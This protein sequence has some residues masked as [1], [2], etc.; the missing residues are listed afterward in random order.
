[1]SRIKSLIVRPSSQ[2]EVRPSI[3]YFSVSAF[4]KNDF[5]LPHAFRINRGANWRIKTNHEGF[6]YQLHNDISLLRGHRF[7]SRSV[8]QVLNH[9][10]KAHA[11]LLY[12][13]ILFVACILYA[14]VSLHIQCS[15]TKIRRGRSDTRHSEELRGMFDP[16]M[17]FI[18]RCYQQVDSRS[19][20]IF[21][22]TF[23]NLSHFYFFF[24]VTL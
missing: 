24:S 1:M 16:P 7:S 18:F 10:F 3:F 19:Q 17:S 23:L 15:S 13:N 12:T 8:L 6:E 20:V 14:Q 11:L 5:C 21:T 9:L 2:S 22:S 4:S